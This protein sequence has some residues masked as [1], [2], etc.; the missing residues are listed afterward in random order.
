M[1]SRVI[2]F[3]ET[4]Y[5]EY[6]AGEW[7]LARFSN[8]PS[9]KWFLCHFELGVTHEFY[10]YRIAADEINFYDAS[11]EPG[12][13]SVWNTYMARKK[14]KLCKIL[15][16]YINSQDLA[17]SGAK[18]RKKRMK[19]STKMLKEEMH[20]EHV[21]KNLSASVLKRT[22]KRLRGAVESLNDNKD[23]LPAMFHS[24]RRIHMF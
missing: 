4:P 16:T 17:N 21:G 23:L 10:R 14:R 19:A 13:L 20:A 1:V 18:V 5:L 11:P 3:I 9:A 2:K 8:T 12:L 7:V 22:P 24:S 6:V 15:E